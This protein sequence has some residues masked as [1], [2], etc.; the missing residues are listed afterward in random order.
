[1]VILDISLLFI[2]L[3]LGLA[4]G[5]VP[6]DQDHQRQDKHDVGNKDGVGDGR[7]CLRPEK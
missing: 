4:V 1:M 7:H 5:T 6:V 3:A 2:F